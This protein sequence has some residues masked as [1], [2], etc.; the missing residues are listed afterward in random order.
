M[1]GPVSTSSQLRYRDADP[2]E[3]AEPVSDL[4][5]VPPAI[6]IVAVRV[7]L[8]E[9]MRGAVPSLQKLRSRIPPPRLDAATAPWLAGAIMLVGISVLVI[10]DLRG[11]AR[12]ATPPAAI[13][14]AG[15]IPRA[16]P[17]AEPAAIVVA[18]TIKPE[19]VVIPKSKPLP[20]VDLPAAPR[21]ATTPRASKPQEKTPPAPVAAPEKTRAPKAIAAAPESP[22]VFGSQTVVYRPPAAAAPAVAETAD[23]EA[24]RSD[25]QLAS[26]AGPDLALIAS[27]QGGE[28]VVMPYRKGDRLPDGSTI[29]AIDAGRH[30]VV[31]SAGTLGPK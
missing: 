10:H 3:A 11:P 19:T 24:P 23:D 18:P 25:Y 14:P 1:T 6:E 15:A 2:V 29:T 17:I 16:A 31:T 28:T 27:L 30:L 8:R 7:P 13:A 26:I 5:P 21:V 20:M 9:R 22:A 4:S 12:V